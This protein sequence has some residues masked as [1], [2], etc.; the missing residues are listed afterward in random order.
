MILTPRK[1]DFNIRVADTMVILQDGTI[2]D[3]SSGLSET[4]FGYTVSE[5]EP[6]ATL[7][8]DLFTFYHTQPYAQGFVHSGSLNLS[9]SMEMKWLT[10]RVVA[11]EADDDWTGDGYVLR[12][13]WTGQIPDDDAEGPEITNMTYSSYAECSETVAVSARITDGSGI[14]INENSKYE[15]QIYW[16][17]S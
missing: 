15:V 10:L 6:T 1:L 2:L 8:D 9:S 14:K 16:S 5:N 11:T 17:Y 7:N 3:Y 4:I 13:D 12:R